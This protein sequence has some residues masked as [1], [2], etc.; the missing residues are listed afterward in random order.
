MKAFDDGPQN[1]ETAE[2]AFIFFQELEVMTSDPLSNRTVAMK[3]HGYH[4]GHGWWIRYEKWVSIN[5]IQD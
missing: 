2:K 5:E 4:D 3:R 1:K